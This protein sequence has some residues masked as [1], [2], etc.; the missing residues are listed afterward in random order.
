[1][2]GANIVPIRPACEICGRPDY[3]F[4][5]IRLAFHYGSAYDAFPDVPDLT[6][7]VCGTCIDRIYRFIQK[8]ADSAKRPKRPKG[9]VGQGGNTD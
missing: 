2:N 3:S 5:E 6:L 9:K 7:S 8:E 1:M 4:S